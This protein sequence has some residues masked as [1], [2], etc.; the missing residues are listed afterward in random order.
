M[1]CSDAHLRCQACSDID[2]NPGSALIVVP[3]TLVAAMLN[4]GLMLMM[5]VEP[6]RLVVVISESATGA[7]G[8]EGDSQG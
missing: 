1:T 7:G 6:T 3:I 5:F 4:K 2:E 8:D